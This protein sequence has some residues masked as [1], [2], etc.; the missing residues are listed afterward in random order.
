[1]TRKRKK[2]KGSGTPLLNNGIYAVKG[3]KNKR[4]TKKDAYK[5]N[6]KVTKQS[7]DALEKGAQMAKIEAYMKEHN[8]SMTQAMVHFM[9]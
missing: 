6:A 1:M 8:V 9:E 2:A 3:S 7:K 4:L 5:V